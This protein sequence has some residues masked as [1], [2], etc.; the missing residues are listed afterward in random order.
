MSKPTQ[1][2]TT[3]FGRVGFFAVQS[4]TALSS[5]ACEFDYARVAGCASD[6]VRCGGAMSTPKHIHGDG[7]F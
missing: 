6:D 2:S 1:L 7:T 4:S 5:C 3:V